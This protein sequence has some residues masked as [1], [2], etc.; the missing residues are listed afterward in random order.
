MIRSPLLSLWFCLLAYPIVAP[1]Q[2]G[3]LVG[4]TLDPHEYDDCRNS[5]YIFA[6][7]QPA[8]IVPMAGEPVDGLMVNFN[9]HTQA[10]ELKQDGLRMELEIGRLMGIQL[11]QMDSLCGFPTF[12]KLLK[13]KL[14]NNF[15]LFLYQGSRYKLL[16][17]FRATLAENKV[18]SPGKTV[19][20]KTFNAISTY[21]ILEGTDLAP[22]KLNRQDLLKRFP[23]PAVVEFTDAEGL[24]LDT[25]ESVCRLLYWMENRGR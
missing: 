16:K 6:E 24:S 9:G 10:F 19:K 11:E 8:I 22:V 20:F 23:E 18:D 15:P 4:K 21:Y 3:K 12:L 13:P 1:A 7:F 25:E 17:D 2:S 14:L 5:P